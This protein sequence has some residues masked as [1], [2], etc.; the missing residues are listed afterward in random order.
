MARLRVAEGR[1]YA[2]ENRLSYNE[3]K[4]INGAKVGTENRDE[5]IS[6]QDR[7]MSTEKEIAV[8]KA[9]FDGIET[10]RSNDNEDLN[11]L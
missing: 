2:A 5:I 4:M 3:A 7:V 1:I 9:K 8:L 10:K 6:L 11:S